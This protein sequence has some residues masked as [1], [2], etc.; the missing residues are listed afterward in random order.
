[1]LMLLEVG[2]F[3]G[4]GRCVCVSMATTGAPSTSV[5]E[6]CCFASSIL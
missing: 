3:G 5:F 6:G 1:M 4:V 2:S